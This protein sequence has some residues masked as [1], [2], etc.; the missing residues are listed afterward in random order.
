M[1]HSAICPNVRFS[2]F[3]LQCSVQLRSTSLYRFF[4]SDNVASPVPE[5]NP[6]G[7]AQSGP[8]THYRWIASRD[9]RGAVNPFPGTKSR[10]DQTRLKL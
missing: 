5:G 6:I 4:P 2:F 9:S 1:L 10:I 8:T 7:R 3:F